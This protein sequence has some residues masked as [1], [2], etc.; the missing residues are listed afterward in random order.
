MLERLQVRGL[1]I[2]DAVEVELAP[3]FVA[4]TGET[5]AGKSLLVT[6]L[7]LLAGRRGQSDLVRTGDE[8]L[9]VDGWFSAADGGRLGPLLE[10]LGA[11]ADGELV[12]RRELSATGR[13]RCFVNDQPVTVGAL[14]R[15][16]PHLLSIHG[17]HEQHGL[18][19][20]G[21]Q[22]QLIDTA[23]GHDG[24]LTEVQARFAAWRTAADEHASLEAARASRRDRLDAIAFQ[25]GEIEAVD[26]RP[27]EHDE[28]T[29]R[30]GVLRNA[31]RL[32]ELVAALSGR[33]SEDDDSAVVR[34]ARAEREVEEMVELGLPLAFPG[35]ELGRA[36]VQVEE[37]VREVQALAAGIDGDPGELDAVETRLHRLD[38][39]MLKY[40]EPLSKVLEHRDALLAERARLEAV[41]DRLGAAAAAAAEALAAYDGAAVELDRARRDAGEALARSVERVLARLNMAGTRMRFDWQTRPDESS[42]LVR[43]GQAVAFDEGGVEVCD[44]LI[45]ANPGEEPRPMARIA[46]GGELSRIHLALRT[47][48]RAARPDGELTLLFDEVDSG[49]GGAT[50]AALA[51]LLRDLAAT[52]QVLVVTHL[53]QVAAAAGS[54]LRVDKRLVDGRAVTRV[55][56]LAGAARELEIARMLAG[57]EV[58]ESARAHARALLEGP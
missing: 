14:A 56:A 39:L 17:Q 34:M 3:G 28:L 42:P 19:D 38:R 12:I 1:G 9:K 37:L 13:G 23:G 24:L 21:V 27:D 6:S 16:A 55:E 20:P 29:A 30:R 8:A 18:A 47:V 49:L 15:L 25:L 52:D 51:G 26:P 41:E 57:D 58:G 31:T 10:E 46:S 45:A 33:L 35:E 22:R 4:L 40:G 43:G 2:I 32:G 36:R 53:P 44:L 50:A 7:E 5:G 11:T 54:H 48:L